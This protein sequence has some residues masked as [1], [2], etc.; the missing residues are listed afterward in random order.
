VPE[1]ELD[2]VAR[3]DLELNSGDGN[4]AGSV[5]W[6]PSATSVTTM[7]YVIPVGAKC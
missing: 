5:Q 3:L 2:L 6:V 1:A 4:A 7:S